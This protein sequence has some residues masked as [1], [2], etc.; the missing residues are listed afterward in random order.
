MMEEILDVLTAAVTLGAVQ[1][2][3]V[4][5]TGSVVAEYKDAKE[6]VTTA[7]KRSD[8]AILSV[9]HER[10]P[11]IGP[12]IAFQLEESG[13]FGSPSNK[14]AGADP[15]DGTNHFAAGGNLYS[16]QA[17]YVEEGLPLVGVVFQPEVYLPLEETDECV[18]RMALGIRGQGAFVR[19]S[20]FRRDTFDFG[21]ARR[22]TK[23]SLPK[24]RTYVSCVPF[25]TK[26]TPAEQDRT[27]K[28]YDSG[29]ISSTTGTG[30]AGGNVMMTIL[31]GQH[32][33]ANFGAGEDLDLIP[34]Q[35]IAEEAGMTVWGIDRRSPVWNVRK[36]PFIVASTPEIAEELL[37]AAE[38]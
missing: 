17:H 36:Q 35:V 1:V 18:G 32:V 21:A 15:L 5:R 31:G 27:K 30:G 29:I 16:V 13:L 7:D 37:G 26:M 23:R 34:P 6:L 19:R 14:K 22:L 9:F 25:S 3:T 4:K 2:L 11:R 10:L 28:V 12:A 24:T 8:A 33:Y 20:L 38:L